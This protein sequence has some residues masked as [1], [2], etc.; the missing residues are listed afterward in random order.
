M[1]NITF[2]DDNRQTSLV[3]HNTYEPTLEM[4]KQGKLLKG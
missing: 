4:I 1:G 3:T 2:Q